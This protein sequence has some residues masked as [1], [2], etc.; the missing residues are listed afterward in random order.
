M[1]GIGVPQLTSEETQVRAGRH[2]QELVRTGQFAQRHTGSPP[3]DYRDFPR[4]APNWTSGCPVTP[5][6]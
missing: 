3:R 6:G 1:G 5:F 4:S 2:H